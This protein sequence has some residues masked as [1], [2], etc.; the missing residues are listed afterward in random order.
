[1]VGGHCQGGSETIC[2]KD[3]NNIFLTSFDKFINQKM[4]T[5]KS[6]MYHG[7]EIKFPNKNYEVLSFNPNNEKT[8]FEK[9]KVFTKRKHNKLLKIKTSIGKEIIVSD[10]HP[11]IIK[12]NEQYNVKLA[13]DITKNDEIPVIT[14]LPVVYQQQQINLIDLFAKSTLISKIRV[15]LKN[16]NWRD[17]KNLICKTN[18]DKKVSNFLNLN[19]L[20][21]VDYLK[22]REKFLELSHE[23]ELLLATGRGPSFSSIPAIFDIDKNF[24]RFIGYYLSEGCLTEDKSLRTRITL[25]KQEHELLDDLTNILNNWQIKFSIYQDKQFNAQTL[26]ISNRLFAEMLR[27]LDAGKDSYDVNIPNIIMFNNDSIRFEVLKG[28]LRGDGGFSLPAKFSYFSSSKKLF[29]QVVL[30]LHNFDIFPF[31]QKREGLLEINA[32][33]QLEK[34]TDFVLDNKKTKLM[35]ALNN[36]SRY[37]K[38][39]NY[40]QA[41]DFFISKVKNITSEINDTFVYSLEVP[42]T[43]NYITTNGIMTHNCI[44][45]DPYYLTYKAKQLGYRPEV[46]SAGRRINDG[47]G[48]FVVEQAVKQMILDGH[49]VKGAKV[50]ILG[51]TFKEDCP[52]LRNSRVIDLIKEFRSYGIEPLVHDSMASHEEA[53]KEYG[54]NLVSWAEISNIEHLVLA[55]AHRFYRELNIDE[56]KKK[57]IKNAH[58][59]DVKSFLDRDA[60][61]NAGIKIWR[62]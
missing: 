2:I 33:R 49:Q 51:L 13:Q 8:S 21:F 24:A 52:D 5:K 22:I 47:M 11:V 60:F 54:V 46:I 36:I 41:D 4:E 45:I 35:T 6:I 34:L 18:L 39:N 59:S 17:F 25:N 9:V 20:P 14:K 43:S 50:A 31:L 29:E 28:V 7:T 23:N 16:K 27:H 57:L 3:G 42:S 32:K 19:Y 1:L 56:Y 40:Y 48:K 61:A 37:A 30:L 10:K 15:K 55:V 38:S 62:L 53:Q 26:K 58:I 12:E 44:G